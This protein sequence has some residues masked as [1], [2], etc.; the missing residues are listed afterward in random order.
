MKEEQKLDI[1]RPL[2][3]AG[4]G[5]R[6]GGGRRVV[7][8]AVVRGMVCTGRGGGPGVIGVGVEEMGGGGAVGGGGR[9]DEGKGR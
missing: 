8:V 7:V 2:E 3:S 9:S 5:A 4:R 1:L 6:G